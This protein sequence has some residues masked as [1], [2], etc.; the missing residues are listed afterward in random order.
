MKAII[1]GGGIGGLTT[2]LALQ[3][4]GIDYEVFEAAPELREVG[5][6]I[7]IPTNAMNVLERLEVADKIKAAGKLMQEICVGDY[8]GK[9]WQSISASEIIPIYGNGTT[10]IHRGHLQ[11]L[12]YGELDK[13]KVHVNKR[14]THFKEE[15]KEMHVFFQ[16]GSSA[17]GDLLLGADGIHSVVRKQ[18]F[19][20]VPLRYSGQTC[21]RA[22][23]DFNLPPEFSDKMFER[24]GSSGGLRF[25][26][27][28]MNDSQ[29]YFYATAAATPGGKDQLGTLIKSLKIR[30]ESFG[31]L[32]ME[33]IESA[34][35]GA[36]IRTDLYDFKPIPSWVKGRIA[37]LGDA[38]HATTPNLGQGG[39]QAIEDAYVVAKCLDQHAK[40]KKA[41]KAYQEIRYKK[42]V[43]VVNTS[44]QYGKLSNMSN[45]TLVA[46]RNLVM[47]NVP[48]KIGE[49][50]LEKIYKLNY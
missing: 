12:L 3:Q 19:G 43:F 24:W 33:I 25:A 39:A 4:R 20:E 34:R 14:F 31:P 49:K 13:N 16:D 48:K 22:S 45:S 27:S 10:T 8:R 17:T 6:G 42:A 38:A 5:A 40:I 26:Y 29:V 41:L 50:Q 2:A 32:A 30:Y 9:I 7:W 1:I 28:R 23:A 21:W 46:L 44:W 36:I 37:L 18:L 35:P 15:G 11:A 47:A